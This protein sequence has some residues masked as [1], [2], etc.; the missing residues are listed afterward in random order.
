M[1]IYIIIPCYNEEEFLEKTLSSLVNQT[2]KAK[3]IL[4]VNDNSTDGSEEIINAFAKAHPEISTLKTQ[5]DAQHL[6]GSK[7]VNAFNLGLAQVD[8]NFDIICKFDADLIFPSN[9][10]EEIAKIFYQNRKAGMVGGF[11]HIK[12]GEAWELENLTNKDHIRGALKAYRKECF[13]DIQ[14]LK[15]A[16]R[17]GFVLSFIAS[18]KLALKKK[19]IGLFWDYMRGYFRAKRKQKQHL[20]S[21]A[22]GAFIRKLRWRGIRHKVLKS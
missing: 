16:I 12:K 11:C 3:K 6:P 22:E 21:K 20:V 14:G 7:V 17:Y 13:T 5:Q 9:Y 4:V 2:L 15:P 18:L 19:N 1:D 8:D 10:L